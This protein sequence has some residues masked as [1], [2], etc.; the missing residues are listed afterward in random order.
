M[1]VIVVQEDKTVKVEEH[2]PPKPQGNEIL[3][4]VLA[5]SLPLLSYIM[6]ATA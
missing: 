6:G 5:C 4:V 2:S 3:C 1:R